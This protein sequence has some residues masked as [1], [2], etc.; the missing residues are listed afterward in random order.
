MK[1]GSPPMPVLLV[2]A[3][4]LLVAGILTTYTAGIYASTT[5]FGVGILLFFGIALYNTKI[6]A[7]KPTA[8][9]SITVAVVLAIIMASTLFTIVQTTI[10]VCGDGICAPYEC[11]ENCEDCTPDDCLNGICQRPLETC[12]NSPDCS[13]PGGTICVPERPGVDPTGCFWIK[14]GDNYCDKG[15]SSKNCCSD[16][17]CEAGYEC[18]QNQCFFLPPKMAFN[19]F[20][21]SDEIGASTL[22]ANPNLRNESGT[23]HPLV[24]L[25]LTNQGS[26]ASDV[27]VR[28]KLDEVFEESFSVGSMDKGDNK[29]VLWFLD[30]TPLYLSIVEDIDTNITVTV[31]YTTTE[32]IR[33]SFSV[34]YPIKI[35]NRGKLDDIGELAYYVTKDIKPNGKTIDM[36]WEEYRKQLE[37][38]PNDGIIQY[39][40]ETLIYGGG[41]D[42]DLAVFF[43]SAFYGAGKITQF[44]NTT[45]GMMLWV[46]YRGNYEV[47]DTRHVDLNFAKALDSRPERTTLS[48]F[49]EVW[50]MHSIEPTT[51][52]ARML[53]GMKII[54][55]SEVSQECDCVSY[56]GQKVEAIHKIINRGLVKSKLCAKSTIELNDE[57]LNQK[58]WCFSVSPE[59]LISLEHLWKSNSTCQDVDVE[60]KVWNATFS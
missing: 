8:I 41:D 37:L 34:N 54:S 10:P 5:V 3:T 15:E 11:D 23:P 25:D 22:A 39:P 33:N 36:I 9:V 60:I 26:F 32:N 35:L 29:D 48:S 49:D 52:D 24:A 30:E 19:T 38:R 42:K 21:F 44:A 2:L 59:H 40:L 17:K 4:S 6:D 18:R 51:F 28:F 13:C 43:A 47:L 56:C 53:P 20:L 14:C 55:S 58:E 45:D 12:E 16:C 46:R 7:G 27:R 57:I 31:E 50:E 1:K